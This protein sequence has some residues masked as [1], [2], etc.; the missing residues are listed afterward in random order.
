MAITRTI[1]FKWEPHIQKFVFYQVC[2]YIQKAKLGSYVVKPEAKTLD[3]ARR[4]TQWP[5]DSRGIQCPLQVK[6]KC[7]LGGWSLIPYHQS[8]WPC[9]YFHIKKR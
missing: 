5:I 4:S 3:L 2:I 1:L 8:F 7:V 9:P 6:A